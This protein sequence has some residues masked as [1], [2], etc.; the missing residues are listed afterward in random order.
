MTGLPVQTA[1]PAYRGQKGLFNHDDHEGHEE[2]HIVQ[3]FFK[4]F[5]AFMVME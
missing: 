5:M 4:R 2:K 3:T 1:Y